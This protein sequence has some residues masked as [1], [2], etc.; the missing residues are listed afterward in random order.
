MGSIPPQLPPLDPTAGTALVRML[1]GM[2][3]ELRRWRPKVHPQVW[4]DGLGELL[5]LCEEVLHPGQGDEGRR[6]AVGVS[7]WLLD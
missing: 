5:A 3:A 7:M 6:K 4:G 1:R 2:A